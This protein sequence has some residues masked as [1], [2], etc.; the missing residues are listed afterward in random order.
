MYPATLSHKLN[1]WK[2]SRPFLKSAGAQK[3]KQ[4]CLHFPESTG[5]AKQGPCGEEIGS[6]GL[7]SSKN[8]RRLREKEKKKTNGRKRKGRRSHFNSSEYSINKE[9]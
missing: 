3:R 4:G 5:R 7:S 8:E 1:F 9:S 6:G 2:A